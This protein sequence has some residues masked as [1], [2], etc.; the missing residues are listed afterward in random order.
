MKGLAKYLRPDAWYMLLTVTIKIVA[1]VLELIVPYLMEQMLDVHVPGG[2]V[3]AIYLCGGG[4]LLCAFGCLFFNIMANRMSAYSSG[5]ITQAIRHDL[6][7]KLESLSARQM[8]A[9]TTPSAVSRL[10]SE[11]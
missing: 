9:L 7:A 3:R 10:T 8:D 2:N 6:F 1:P 4:M 11:T 5:K